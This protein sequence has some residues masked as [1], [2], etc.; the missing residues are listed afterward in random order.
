LRRR[1][2]HATK[3]WSEFSSGIQDTVFRWATAQVQNPFPR[4]VHFAT[5]ASSQR[6]LR[7]QQEKLNRG[8]RLGGDQ[9]WQFVWDSTGRTS[10]DPNA[11]QG[12][13][14]LSTNTS[15]EWTPRYVRIRLGDRIASDRDSSPT[16]QEIEERGGETES[17]PL[18]S[19]GATLRIPE[20][21]VVARIPAITSDRT[22]APNNQYDY[23]TVPCDFTDPQ[24]SRQL[25]EQE[26]DSLVFTNAQRLKSQADSL[27]RRTNLEMTQVVPVILILCEDPNGGTSPVNLNEL[28]FMASP[29]EF[30]SEPGFDTFEERGLA[31]IESFEV[32]VQEPS[33]G[34]VTGI[35]MATLSLKVHNPLTISRDHSRG[36]YLSYLMQQGFVIRVRYGIEGGGDSGDPD[37]A[38]AFQWREEDF[39]VSSYTFSIANDFSCVMRIS[40]M[41]GT[42]RLLNQIKIGQSLPMTSLG[43]ISDD[44]L[45]NIVSSVVS[46]RTGQD[47]SQTEALRSHLRTFEEQLNTSL[48]RAGVGM[49]EDPGQNTF[50]S[51]L[52]A[53]LGNGRIFAQDESLA[54]I[55]V[56]NFVEGIRG[57]QNVL[58]TRRFQSLL[59]QDCYR[60]TSARDISTSVINLG[61]LVYNIAKPEIDY[62]FSVISRNQIEIGEKFSSDSSDAAFEGNRRTNVKLVFGRFNSQAGSWAAKPISAFPINV[63]NIFA[64][65]RQSR[66]IGDF[67]STINAFLN[68][69]FRNAGEMENYDSDISQGSDEIR[70]RLQLPSIKYVIYPSPANNTDWIMYVYDSKVHT[71]R[72]RAA[73]DRLTE[74]FRSSR[75][76]PTVEQIKEILQQNSVP[77][78]EMAE[79][80]NFIK[81]F[82][83]EAEADDLLASHNLLAASRQS[84][85]TRDLDNTVSMPAGISRDFLASMQSSQQN[86]IS[87][88]E[89]VPPM[90][91]SVNSFMLP[92]V[93]LFAPIFIF[94]PIRTVTGIYNVTQIKHDLKAGGAMTNLSLQL[95]M[96]VFNLMAT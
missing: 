72:V 78:L 32:T 95:D 62:T 27:K 46:S 15:R 90:R 33:V 43:R 80:G 93:F 75:V 39:F 47:Q 96:S 74:E 41:P 12:N 85:H 40:L 54:A 31:S 52:H 9:G 48:R 1:D 14:F 68:S 76:R 35:S 7:E 61:P 60:M 84:V 92:T 45:N 79:Q 94:F 8:E 10:I 81:S 44:E 38:Q 56:E 63:E 5:P 50:G 37:V 4:A 53:A 87:T 57:I 6:G 71:V 23:V 51:H 24:A 67:S 70:R 42:H 30:S 36:K 34:G 21:R 65:L 91:V 49:T 88:R 66:N 77:W 58:L 59:Q 64:H 3:Q 22:S 2:E 29:Y 73:I 89:Y 26:E 13:L 82:S 28:I 19:G 69:A 25:S 18:D 16:Q 83:G 20:N 11:R 86:V 55:P 17:R